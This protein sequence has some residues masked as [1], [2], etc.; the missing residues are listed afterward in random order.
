MAVPV[1]PMGDVGKMMERR[2]PFGSALLWGW[3]AAS[4]SC[5][6]EDEDDMTDFIWK[7]RVAWLAVIVVV[8]VALDQGTKLWA[9]D[10]L[11]RPATPEE[12]QLSSSCQ[13]SAFRKEHRAEC[14]TNPRI[15]EHGARVIERDITIIPGLF[16]FKYAENPAAAF[17]MTGS[18]PDWFRRPFLLMISLLASIGIAVWYLKLKV[19]DWAVMTAFPLIISGAVGNLIDR[20]RLAYVI[21]FLDFYLASPDSVSAWL[22]QTFRTNHWPTFNIADSCIVVGALLVIFRTFKNPPKPAESVADGAV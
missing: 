6:G 1:A 2:C 19:A 17:S 13:D 14:R 3:H 8:G 16:N 18:M 5:A 20:A 22:V 9:M 7:N 10:A 11:T 15:T 4:A 21:D 12:V